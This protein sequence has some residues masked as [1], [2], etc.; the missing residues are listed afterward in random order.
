MGELL[1]RVEESIFLYK[2]KRLS[3]ADF[4]KR[5]SD[6]LVEI[7]RTRIVNSRL[8]K[9]LELG[10]CISLLNSATPQTILPCAKII[11]E[12]VKLLENFNVDLSEGGTLHF[13]DLAVGDILIHS[14]SR[15]PTLYA[16]VISIMQSG[17]VHASIV[18]R[19]TS[20]SVIVAESTT[21]AD[22]VRFREI[23]PNTIFRD[24]VLRADLTAKHR[25]ALAGAI[26]RRFTQKPTYSKREVIGA[27]FSSLVY[28]VF[29]IDFA[30]RFS[31]AESYFCSEFVDKCYLD[32]GLDL[33]PKKHSE[34]VVPKDFLQSPVL[35]KYVLVT[36]RVPNR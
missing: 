7:S 27:A 11:A 12:K 35:I 13:S 34:T 10:Y 2:K 29:H 32:A 24:V 3:Y 31:D 20:N 17:N 23:H 33:V 36:G 28:D 6:F 15:T 1:R 14:K 19:K 9:Q 26:R 16:R 8:Q 22:G 4:T 21:H 5:L 25:A 30:N 18:V